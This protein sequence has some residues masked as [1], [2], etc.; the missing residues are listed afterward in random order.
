MSIPIPLLSFTDSFQPKKTRASTSKRPVIK[1]HAPR[2]SVTPSDDYAP[3]I[4]AMNDDKSEVD[5]EDGDEP[6]TNP[7]RG[8]RIRSDGVPIRGLGKNSQPFLD[9]GSRAR[10]QVDALGSAIRGYQYVKRRMVS[11]IPSTTF[12]L[13][14]IS[15]H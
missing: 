3:P 15:F 7:G 14:T 1:T 11:F 9:D 13:K 5:Q 8:R 4:E 12:S 6:Q 2:K 10:P